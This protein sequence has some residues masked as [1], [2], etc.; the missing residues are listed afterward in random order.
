MEINIFEIYELLP[1][2]NC[3]NCGKSSCMDFAKSLIDGEITLGACSP[4]R[5]PHYEEQRSEL[6]KQFP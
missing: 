6:K 1:R 3:K 5:N 4:L 2:N